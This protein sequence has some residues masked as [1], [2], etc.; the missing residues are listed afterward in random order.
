[1]IKYPIVD[2]TA[3]I[4]PS[5]DVLGDVK[6]G[7]NASV[8]HHA[9]IRGDVSHIEIGDESNIQDNCVIHVNSHDPAVIGRRV[10]VGHSAIIHSCTIGDGTLV[11][12]GAIVMDA[13][14]VG[15]ECLVGA[16][17]LITR[18]KEIPDHS[19]VMGSPAKVIRQLTDEEIESLSSSADKYLAAKE[20]F[21]RG[22]IGRWEEE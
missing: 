21:E 3:F 10:T 6:I 20:A 19:L 2:K 14:K 18:G 17:A 9:T 7:K 13:A 5:A 8:W 11:G 1:M 15:R 4:A 22:D 16:G 12:M